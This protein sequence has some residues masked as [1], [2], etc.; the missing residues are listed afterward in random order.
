MI[1]GLP[2]SYHGNYYPKHQ[3]PHSDLVPTTSTTFR[4]F[5][6]P[7]Y[8]NMPLFSCIFFHLFY[9][10]HI[11]IYRALIPTA[12]WLFVE[13]TEAAPLQGVGPIFNHPPI[14]LSVDKTQVAGIQQTEDWRHHAIPFSLHSLSCWL[15]D[16]RLVKF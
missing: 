4:L 6:A 3:Q 8:S 12:F 14:Q 5:L 13:D 9:K 11:Q 10:K 16:D 2:P 1:S 15:I 7:K